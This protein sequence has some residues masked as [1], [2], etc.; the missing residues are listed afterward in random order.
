[1]LIHAL[2]KFSF[3]VTI[4]TLSL[5]CFALHEARAD[6]K[7]IP[8]SNRFQSASY[9]YARQVESCTTWRKP[10]RVSDN[11]GGV[12][13]AGAC[14]LHDRCYH[15]AGSS[16][17][18]CNQQFLTAMH[19]AC[20]RDLERQRLEKGQHGRPDG[21][22]VALCYEISDLYFAKVQASDAQKRFELAQSQQQEYLKY[23][24]TVVSSIYQSVLRRPATEKEAT[25]ALAT[26]AQD[27]SLDDLK[28]ALMG[29]KLNRDQAQAD[30]LPPIDESAG[31]AVETSGS[32]LPVTAEPVVVP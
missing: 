23:V 2:K 3:L 16:W 22:A 31:Q 20:D 11:W 17:G 12:S 24:R 9:P 4:V 29:E 18:D 25:R 21:Q 1:M 5:L 13:F 32:V 19:Q 26:L 7:G 28:A 6:V 14:Q 30:P 27:Y 10:D 8:Y 15:T